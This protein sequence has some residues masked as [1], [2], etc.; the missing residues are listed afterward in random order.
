MSV[1]LF[2]TYDMSNTY[3]DI[4]GLTKPSNFVKADVSQNI[5][6]TT[7]SSL[8]LNINSS[9]DVNSVNIKNYIIDFSGNNGTNA[10][11]ATRTL[12][13]TT[14]TAHSTNTDVTLSDLSANTLYDLSAHLVN[15]YDM[16]NNKLDLSGVTRPTNF[17]ASDITQNIGASTHNKLVMN[18]S[19]GQVAGTLDI[20]GYTIDVSGIM[21]LM[22]RDKLLLKQQQ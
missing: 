22:Q 8:I 9:Q 13:P 12:N 7:A 10:T 16:S 20:S 18:V 2:N 1:Y 14:A 15:L 21:A 3:I 19:H 6:S 5:G 11:A 4:S 17:V